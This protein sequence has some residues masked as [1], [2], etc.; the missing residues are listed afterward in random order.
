MDSGLSKKKFIGLKGFYHGFGAMSFVFFTLIALVLIGCSS[1]QNVGQT[2]DTQ[3]IGDQNDKVFDDATPDTTDTSGDTDDPVTT[4]TLALTAKNFVFL[5]DG[6]E[7]P[8]LRVKEGDTVKI[9]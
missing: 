8:T 1:N 7:N 4:K 6:K 3:L 2:A 9:E 5:M